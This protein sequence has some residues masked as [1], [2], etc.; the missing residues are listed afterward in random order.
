MTATSTAALLDTPL[1]S[2]TALY[3]STERPSGNAA[4]RSRISTTSAP[5]TYAAQL[6]ARARASARFSNCYFRAGK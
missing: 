1:P 4:P 3:T 5:A 6:R 2:G